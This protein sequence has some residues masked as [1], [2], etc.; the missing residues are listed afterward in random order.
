[1][2]KGG[3]TPVSEI[4]TKAPVTLGPADTLDLANDIIQLGRIR[5]IPIVDGGK[6]VGILSQRDLFGAAVT[7]VL[8]I[9][10][11]TQ[12]EL[13]RSVPI[14]EVM[15]KHLITIHPD[16]SVRQAAS[17]MAT[18]KIGSLPVV[19]G[20]SLVGLVTQ[21]DILRYVGREAL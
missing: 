13:L 3:D 7:A 15:R 6:L 9:T 20:G 1:M 17:L 16:A 4:M 5:H 14:R 11:K 10:G 19:E 8:G 21:T 18:E 2:W 12:R